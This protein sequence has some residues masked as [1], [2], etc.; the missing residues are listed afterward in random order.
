MK[1]PPPSFIAPR[2]RTETH[3]DRGRLSRPDLLAQ[4][5]ASSIHQ[6]AS[7]RV[8]SAGS[9]SLRG[10]VRQGPAR[11]F[12]EQA[13][14]RTLEHMRRSQAQ[15]QARTLPVLRRPVRPP[16]IRPL[17]MWLDMPLDLETNHVFTF[18][19]TDEL[20]SLSEVS[21]GGTAATARGILLGVAEEFQ[22]LANDYPAIQEAF[23]WVREQPGV[24]GLGENT[25]LFLQVFRSILS[26][27]DAK[28][29]PSI[30]DLY[31]ALSERL[32]VAQRPVEQ[33]ALRLL[34][35]V[36]V[37]WIATWP[38]RFPRF[39]SNREIAMAAV[40]QDQQV[41]LFW[42][43]R[44]FFSGREVAL[45]AFSEL[46]HDRDLVMAAVQNHEAALNYSGIELRDD[47]EI[48]MAALKLT[49]AALEYAGDALRGNREFMKAAVQLDPRALK[50]AGHELRADP[51]IVLDAVQR[52]GDA[53]KFSALELRRN[54]EI[55]LAAVQSSGRALEHANAAL[56]GDRQIVLAAVQQ[57][58]WALQFA[59]D[60]LRD[61]PEIVMAAVQ[62]DSW[63]LRFA[64]DELRDDPEIVMAAVQNDSWVLRF[65]SDAL[66]NDRKIVLAAVQNDGQALQFASDE[67][68]NDPEIVMAA[69]Q[70]EGKALQHA[71]SGM[72][73]NREIVSAALQQDIL[74][75]RYAGAE[76]QK[77]RR[78]ALRFVEQGGAVQALA[79]PALASDPEIMMAAVQ[80][81]GLALRHAS[82][83]LRNDREIVMAAVQE[84]GRALQYAS[85][86]LR[87]DP[88]VVKV[89]VQRSSS[90]VQ[91]ASPRLKSDPDI[92][93][94][95]RASRIDPR[96]RNR[97][98]PARP[99]GL[100][101]KAAA[102]S[103]G[104]SQSGAATHV[105]AEESIAGLIQEDQ[106]Q[107]DSRSP[108]EGGSWTRQLTQAVAGLRDR[109]AQGWGWMR[110]A[111]SSLLPRR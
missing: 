107:A 4:Q 81:S 88:E 32:V 20:I 79:N 62:N 26:H 44:E 77:S 98:P 108:G 14:A 105:R 12:E 23:Q 91:F 90:A 55:V 101:G 80:K 13:V 2:S 53:L 9:S 69:V 40:L 42:D 65:A 106:P 47:P 70:R 45:A 18:L 61:D 83:E 103:S 59:S 100:A 78:L 36:L 10:R 54:R 74:A 109:A 94:A 66:R 51:Q 29:I 92:L 34:K 21:M 104:P 46:Y 30:G 68:R 50:F 71:S 43:N 25:R 63:V 33:H 31:E 8:G 58:G 86:D 93:K 97:V 84:D 27:S 82:D 1:V 39:K 76:L 37:N 111:F 17:N 73:R 6:L 48:V 16:V 28:E 99:S 5:S 96:Q 35:D 67:L 87:S 95:C 75:L 15:E 72:R 102:S 24:R 3:A 56:R 57:E 60:E 85:L 41:S 19:S 7:S 64:S 110:Q 22:S 11:W 49:P 52:N 89:A 38:R